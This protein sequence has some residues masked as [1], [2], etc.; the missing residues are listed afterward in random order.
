MN[1]SEAVIHHY[2]QCRKEWMKANPIH[3]KLNRY[4]YHMT[5]RSKCLDFRRYRSKVI[6]KLADTIKDDV[7][8]KVMEIGV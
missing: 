5:N 3:K 4:L 6:D 2:R 1:V 8:M 7:L